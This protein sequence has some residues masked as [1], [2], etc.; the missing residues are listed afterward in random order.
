MQPFVVVLGILLGSLVSISFGL[1]V[2]LLIFWILQGDHPRFSSE[3]P[4]LAQSVIIF[5]VLAALAAGG[6][7]GT[8]RRK[9]WRHMVLGVFWVGLLATGW[10]YWPR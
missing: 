6:F 3:L 2:V 8:L 1:A 9:P 7:V 4:M 10:F 5:T